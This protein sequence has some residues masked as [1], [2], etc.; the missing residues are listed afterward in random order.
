MGQDFILKHIFKEQ[1]SSLAQTT[2]QKA[3]QID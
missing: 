2:K 3:N 1:N